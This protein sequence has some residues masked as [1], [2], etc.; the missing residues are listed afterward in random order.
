MPSPA[1][2]GASI[3]T[4]RTMAGLTLREVAEL[5]GVGIGYLSQAETGVVSPKPK[6][7]AHVIGVLGEQLRNKAV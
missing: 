4:L 1:D 2:T 6:W 7:I 5:A 3:R